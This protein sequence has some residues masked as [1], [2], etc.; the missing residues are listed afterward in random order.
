[1]IIEMS[2]QEMLHVFDHGN[3][4]HSSF[5]EQ[6]WEMK[7]KKFCV[8]SVERH[9]S[10]DDF[11]LFQ[12]PRYTYRLEVDFIHTVKSPQEIAAENAVQ[13]AESALKAAKECLNKIKEK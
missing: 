3:Y 2:D 4:F 5:L 12:L 9:C 1:M 7:G 10:V 6:I 13:K 11:T 8:H